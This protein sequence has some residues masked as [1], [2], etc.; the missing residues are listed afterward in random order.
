MNNDQILPNV[1]YLLC[2]LF[3]QCF[4]SSHAPS[5]VGYTCI[6]RNTKG[7]NMVDQFRCLATSRNPS[8]SHP[9]T[10]RAW[11]HTHSHR[12]QYEIYFTSCCQSLCRA[13]L[14]MLS[15]SSIS[16]VY[17]ILYRYIYIFQLN[18]GS[19]YIPKTYYSIFFSFSNVSRVLHGVCW[20]CRIFFDDIPSK[21]YYFTLLIRDWM[22]CSVHRLDIIRD[23][24]VRNLMDAM[25]CRK[26]FK[27]TDCITTMHTSFSLCEP[28]V[29]VSP[30]EIFERL[31]TDRYKRYSFPFISIQTYSAHI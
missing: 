14:S 25:Q 1:R 20:A 29:H 9:H 23:V 8:P 30:S 27:T 11:Q 2:S 31:G 21:L 10:L 7:K 15:F 4:P 19:N 5:V 17:N 26:A 16:Y 12:P 18:R 22:K 3:S 6:K 28:R 24:D 13:R